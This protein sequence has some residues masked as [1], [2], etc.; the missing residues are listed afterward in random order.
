V[1]TSASPEKYGFTMV[2][3]PVGS[4]KQIV[5]PKLL[6]A[7][8]SKNNR[9]IS[10]LVTDYFFNSNDSKTT[11][12]GLYN[13]VQYTGIKFDPSESIIFGF[14]SSKGPIQKVSIKKG[15]IV[16]GNEKLIKA[17]FEL[18]GDVKLSIGSTSTP[19]PNIDIPTSSSSALGTSEFV[20]Y[21][22]TKGK[23]DWHNVWVTPTL[24]QHLKDGDKNVK[25][26]LN[27]V[28]KNCQIRYN[29]NLDSVTV[30]GLVSSS[31]KGVFEGW[32]KNGV[33]QN[34]RFFGTWKKGEFINSI[35]EGGEWFQGHFDKTS[36]FLKGKW[37]KQKYA[38]Q[39]GYRGV[40]F[41]A[42][43]NADIV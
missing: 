17:T 12:A 33:L 10:V 28:I 5:D 8:N 15:K 2:N 42:P 29:R 37:H 27:A 23:G 40:K 32:W 41:A 43:P 20:S 3:K 9:N 22:N 18:I 14:A 4:K 19:D 7:L 16:G 39:G 36:I 34:V 25:W 35:F 31:E 38:Y 30:M 11:I 24:R 13:L 26:L 1:T 6:K 21:I